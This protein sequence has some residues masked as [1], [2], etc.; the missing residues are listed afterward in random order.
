MWRQV[1]IMSLSGVA[2]VLLLILMS[3]CGSV[4]VDGRK[5]TRAKAHA[6]CR[7]MCGGHA[8]IDVHFDHAGELTACR[9]DVVIPDDVSVE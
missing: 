7:E 2:I 4:V 8:P 5:E 6:E 3:H 1:G 9:C